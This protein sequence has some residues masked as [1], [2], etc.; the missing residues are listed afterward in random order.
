V[1]ITFVA[2]MRARLIF[3]FYLGFI[4]AQGG[5][6][7]TIMLITLFICIQFEITIAILISVVAGML[8][9]FYSAS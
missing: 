8:S 3:R 2:A 4:R 7:K 1:E 6:R 9:S 5:L